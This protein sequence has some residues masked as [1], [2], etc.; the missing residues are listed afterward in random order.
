[1]IRTKKID[2]HN[3]IRFNLTRNKNAFVDV[4]TYPVHVELLMLSFLNLV[5][6]LV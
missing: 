3:N 4:C 1:M 6:S 5:A 2:P